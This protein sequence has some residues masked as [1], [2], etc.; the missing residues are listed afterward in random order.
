MK[1]FI[2]GLSGLG[3]LFLIGACTP[4]LVVNPPQD[5]YVDYCSKHPPH[6]NMCP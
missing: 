3:L 6:W 2:C 5:H 4:Q 1:R